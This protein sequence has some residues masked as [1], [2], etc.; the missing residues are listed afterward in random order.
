MMLRMTKMTPGSRLRRGL[1]H[2]VDAHPR[3]W[4]LLP[5][6]AILAVAG[7]LGPGGVDVLEAVASAE[8][9]DQADVVADS[10]RILLW[11]ATGGISIWASGLLGHIVFG[12]GSRW[13]Q[14]AG[15]IALRSPE[16]NAHGPLSLARTER[17]RRRGPPSID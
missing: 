17:T 1:F 7:E 9:L 8:P 3:A 15:S 13:A 11:V 10:T 14:M 6:F 12:L 16:V 5:C 4:L 2:L